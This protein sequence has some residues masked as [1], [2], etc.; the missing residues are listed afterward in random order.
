VFVA[1]ALDLRLIADAL[2]VA[3]MVA[4]AGGSVTFVSRRWTEQTGHDLEG[5][6]GMGWLGVIDERARPA[7][8][9]AWA[10]AIR[11]GTSATFEA[12]VQTASGT[13]RWYRASWLPLRDE[14]G[15]IAAWLGTFFDVDEER[16]ADARLRVSA[17]ANAA[18]AQ[19][20]GLHGTLETL[21]GLL[22]PEYAD[23]AMIN[24]LEGANRLRAVAVS[25]RDPKKSPV[26]ARI[27]NAEMHITG[28]GANANVLATG[29]PVCM[30]QLPFARVEPELRRS[31]VPADVI[32]AFKDLGFA[33]AV[34]VPLTHRGALI[35]VMQMVRSQPRATPYDERD[36]P[37]FGD[38]AAA[39]STAIANAQ[40]FDALLDS[41]RHLA[42][43]SRASDELARSLSLQD[44]Y[45]TFVR[46]VVPELAD[47]AAITIVERGIVTAV[48]A[49]HIDPARSADSLLVTQAARDVIGSGS[50]QIAMLIDEADELRLRSSVT[51][52]LIVDGETYGALSA[53][54]M[55]LDRLFTQEELPLFAELARR[56]S[57]AIGNARR[58]EQEH[59]V[60]TA[61]QAAA[62]PKSL[63]SGG[64][65]SFNGHYTPGRTELQIGGDWYDALRLADGRIMISIG[66]VLGSG[67][68]AATTMS[69]LRQVIRGVAQVHPD[70]S[71]M[72]DAA[73][74][75]LR[76][77]RPDRLVTAFI[78]VLD[79]VT[80]TLTYASA[81]HPA[82]L[83]R[84]PDGTIA[85]LRTTGLPLGLRER[86]DAAT[87]TVEVARGS[88]LVC[89]TD[90][91][92]ESTHDIFEGERRLYAAIS[93]AEIETSAEPARRIHD[94]VLFDGAHDDV[95]ILAVR[96]PGP[97]APD[98]FTRF[99]LHSGDPERVSG[100][101]RAFSIMLAERGADDTAAFTA[102][103]VFGELLGNVARYAPGDFEVAIDFASAEPVLHLLDNGP[104]FRF[105]PNLPDDVLSERGR[106]LYI[107]SSLAKSFSVDA[108]LGGG[109]HARAV[110]E[111]SSRR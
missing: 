71:L 19:T 106:G 36:V 14:R 16:R 35:G 56:A 18:L 90:G 91:L 89:Y 93:D 10:E 79:P 57:A 23:W 47:W 6:L 45:D 20:P 17:A 110:L 22:V 103:L 70:P 104:G 65:Y 92:I 52:P 58:Y 55:A 67:L 49:A 46:I 2:P 84:A 109:S 33:S 80:S 60:A 11:S 53:G 87:A 83:M 38:L 75:T 42:V 63:P 102:E 13:G 28:E 50:P 41:E 29:L 5:A 12:L 85:E 66:D 37:L 34:F 107:V 97:D 111:L 26:C 72:L 32:A 73:D 74:K 9:D 48:S 86:S 76:A 64:G 78:G 62:L 25:H 108:R 105:N 59:R 81:G 88:M 27:R 31:G 96:M 69:N 77:D 99:S 44:T 8:A 98:P 100:V 1:P 68:E 30:P 95:A 61:L 40:I 54:S 7:A 39:A 94:T 43:V 24:L 4:D 82:A 51:V 101:R 3:G 21:V 15:Q